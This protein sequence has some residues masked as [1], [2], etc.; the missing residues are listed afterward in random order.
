MIVKLINYIK[1]IF[2]KEQQC[3]HSMLKFVRAA[4][5]HECF[6]HEG[7]TMFND[8]PYVVGPNT[9]YYPAM[10]ICKDCGEF[11]FGFY[12]VPYMRYIPAY[13]VRN[14]HHAYE[15]EKEKEEKNDYKR[16]N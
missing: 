5:K 11:I 16:N 7:P 4:T 13:V 6:I 2:H 3:D 8:K 1:E 10:W 15:E 12:T 14:A 9:N